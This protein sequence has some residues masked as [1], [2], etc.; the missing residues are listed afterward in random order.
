M[1]KFFYIRKPVTGA[2][3]IIAFM[4]TKKTLWIGGIL[5]PSLD[6]TW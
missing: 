5:F 1:I 2:N 4:Y 6:N 3:N